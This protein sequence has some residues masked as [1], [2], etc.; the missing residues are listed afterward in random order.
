[1][2]TIPGGGG[3]GGYASSAGASGARGQIILTYTAI[4]AATK[5]ITLLGV[6]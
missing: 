2:G 3:S 4:V 6:G 5:Y 1:V